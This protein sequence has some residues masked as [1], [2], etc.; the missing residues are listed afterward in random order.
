MQQGQSRNNGAA[1]SER[2]NHG[3]SI[4]TGP[5]AISSHDEE[6]VGVQEEGKCS[7][8]Q[9]RR[10]HPQ[11]LGHGYFLIKTSSLRDNREAERVRLGL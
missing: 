3:K 11:L 7:D 10:R 8:K 5:Q 9:H 4:I 1:G 2:Y 6:E